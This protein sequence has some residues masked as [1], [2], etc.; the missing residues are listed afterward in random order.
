LNTDPNGVKYALFH[1]VIDKKKEN[2][3]TLNQYIDNLRVF[4]RFQGKSFPWVKAL[5]CKPMERLVIR[6][7]MVERTVLAKQISSMRLHSRSLARRGP[8]TSR[9]VCGVL[10]E[11]QEQRRYD[12]R[13]LSDPSARIEC[14]QAWTTRLGMFRMA[15]S[16]D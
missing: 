16:Y 1:H 8:H 4:Q 12:E 13:I 7:A 11:D 14:I 6:R 5:T 2:N 10:Q 3:Y 15:V 9:T